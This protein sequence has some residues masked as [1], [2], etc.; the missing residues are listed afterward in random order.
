MEPSID[1]LLETIRACSSRIKVASAKA[2]LE[3]KLL[4]ESEETLLIRIRNSSD[5]NEIETAKHV[6]WRKRL[7]DSLDGLLQVVSTSQNDLEIREAAILLGD[8]GYVEAVQPLI[9]LLNSSRSETVRDGAALGLRELADQ[10]ALRP[11][12]HAIREHP[13]DSTLVYALENLNCH[14]VF[15]DLSQLFV[16]KAE[17]PMICSSVYAC[18]EGIQLASVPAYVLEN[19]RHYIQEAIYRTENDEASERLERLMDLISP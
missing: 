9:R 13:E 10:R 7:D 16:S 3:Q 1:Q 18:I 12:M 4:E 19:C 14:E 8:K 17:D 6:L 11:L 2:L 5:N 15:E